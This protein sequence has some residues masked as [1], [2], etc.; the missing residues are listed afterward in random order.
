MVLFPP[1]HVGCPLGFA[2]E[3]ALEDVGLALWGARCEGGAAAWVAGVLAA[4]VLR[5]VGGQGTYRDYSAPEGYDNQYG[6]IHSNI[7]AW[8]TPTP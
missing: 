5:G 3:V 4:L 1:L 6:P 7:L 8:G 2:P